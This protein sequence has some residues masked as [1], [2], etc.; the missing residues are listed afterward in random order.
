MYFYHNALQYSGCS[1]YLT[2]HLQDNWEEQD[3]SKSRALMQ[4]AQA[5]FMMLLFSKIYEKSCNLYLLQGQY[6]VDL[7]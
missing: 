7:V 1:S 4:M 5:V 2:Q 3:T 6:T